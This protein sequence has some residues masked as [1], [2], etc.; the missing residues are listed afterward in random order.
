M[1]IESDMIRVYFSS[2]ASGIDFWEAQ[3]NAW[4]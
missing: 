1:N 3:F 2:S 4:K